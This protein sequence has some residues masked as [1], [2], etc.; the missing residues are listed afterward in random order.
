M[1][2]QNLGINLSFPLLQSSSFDF[3]LLSFLSQQGS[4]WSL[5]RCFVHEGMVI[6]FSEDGLV[7]WL[8]GWLIESGCSCDSLCCILVSETP[9]LSHHSET[10]TRVSIRQYLLFST[11]F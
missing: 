1:Y 2:D 4:R 7:G 11:S 9:I 10:Q 6:V 8:A 5:F 3:R